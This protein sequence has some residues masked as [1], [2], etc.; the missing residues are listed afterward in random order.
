MI[1]TLI[2]QWGADYVEIPESEHQEDY[3][4]RTAYV[5]FLNEESM[6]KT[7]S[8]LKFFNKLNKKN[9]F[10]VPKEDYAEITMNEDKLLSLIAIAI[11]ILNPSICSSTTYS[12]LIK[13]SFTLIFFKQYFY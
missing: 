5:K 7:I 8:C 1:I 11:S 3:L 6:P 2:K 12:T 4:Y 9:I 10:G 13:I